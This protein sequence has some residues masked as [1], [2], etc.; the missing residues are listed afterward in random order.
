MSKGLGGFITDEW[1]SDARNNLGMNFISVK[2]SVFKNERR[3]GPCFCDA[4][5]K[6]D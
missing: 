3:G 6:N 4:M 5:F 2:V 1:E